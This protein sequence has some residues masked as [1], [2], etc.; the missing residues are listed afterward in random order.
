MSHLNTF[1]S[2]VY[3]SYQLEVSAWSVGML[4]EHVDNGGELARQPL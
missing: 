1:V 2:E 3:S 4:G